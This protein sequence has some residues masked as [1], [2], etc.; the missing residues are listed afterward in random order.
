MKGYYL[1]DGALYTYVD[2]EEYTDIFP[3]WDWRKVPGVTCYQEDKRVH[4]MGW[5]EKQNKGSFVGNVNDGNVGMTS[6]ELVRD[7]LYAKKAWIF[8]PDYVLCLGA[9]IHSDSS[10]LVNTSIEQALLKEKL[11]HLEKG[12]WNA[13]KDV[14]FSAY[15]LH[16]N[17]QS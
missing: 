7:G 16:S 2:G 17:L 11:L 14:C 6:M 12:K 8:T 9:D 1:A 4:V 15:L 13:V 3:C 5:L 10:Y